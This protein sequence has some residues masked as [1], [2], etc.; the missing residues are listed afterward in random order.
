MPAITPE[1]A[2]AVVEPPAPE[3]SELDEYLGPRT[4]TKDAPEP[5]A[6]PETP[7]AV[8]ETELIIA[9]APEPDDAKI[10]HDAEMSAETPA[11]AICSECGLEAADTAS[12][13]P[14]M[15]KGCGQAEADRQAKKDEARAKRGK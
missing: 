12:P 6:E 9:N 14:T 10:A 1:P 3:A 4:E 11:G 13:Y 5:S 8:N 7:W 2:P 15:C